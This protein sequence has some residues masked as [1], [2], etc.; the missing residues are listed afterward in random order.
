MLHR[1]IRLAEIFNIA[2][3][4]TNQVEA[5]PDTFFGDPTNELAGKHH[6][7]STYKYLES[8]EKTG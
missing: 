3:I 2:V 4:I 7:T 8:Q 5:T 1:I 6:G